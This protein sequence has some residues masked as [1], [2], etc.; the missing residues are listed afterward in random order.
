M[1]VKVD[2]PDEEYTHIR[3][4]SLS[5]APDDSHYRISVKREE[6]AEGRP[7]GKVSTF[8]HRHINE[9]DTLHVSAPAGDFV[10]NQS[11]ELPVVLLSGGVGLTPLLSMLHTLVKEQPHREV[12]FIHAAINGDYHA[13]G[14]EVAALAQ[15]HPQIHSFVCYQSPT[16]KDQEEKYFDKQ[17]YI[18]LQWLQSILPSNEA[19][20]YFCGPV[21]FMKTMNKSLK[22][23]GV[24]AERI[25]FEFFGPAAELESESS[26]EVQ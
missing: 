10:L 16:E 1:S 7:E 21:P 13:F 24:P 22:D 2:L 12:Y 14:E 25:H 8:L 15:S 19:E 5:A 4:Y 20:F 3:Q 26:D 23:W 6:A 9:G 18:D 17:G 11:S